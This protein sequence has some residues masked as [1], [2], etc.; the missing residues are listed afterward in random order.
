MS[1]R[2]RGCVNYLYSS[3]GWTACTDAEQVGLLERQRHGRGA[4]SLCSVESVGD[5]HRS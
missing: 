2:M 1:E 3:V 5:L 4:C